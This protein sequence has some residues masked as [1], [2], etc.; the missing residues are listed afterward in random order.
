[1]TLIDVA[2]L[3]CPREFRDGYRRDMQGDFWRDAFDIARTGIA[4]RLES[5]ARDV[6]FA[7]RTLAKARVFT[8]V[9]VLTLALAISVNAT[10]F[11]AISS[12][13]LRPLPFAHSEQLAFLCNGSATNCS[14]MPNSLITKYR[15]AL[16]GAGRI[17][18]WQYTSAALT[19][20]GVPR[21][22]D[23]GWVSAN[24]FDLMNVRPQLGR[25]FDAHDA[26]PGV[27]EV[28]I[29]DRLWRDRFNADPRVIGK[30]LY[31]DGVA[32]NVAGVLPARLAWPDWG[33]APA[34]STFEV[35][36]ALPAGSFAFP[37]AKPF[38]NDL[39]I[40]RIRPG[41]SIAQ[42][43]QKISS[44][45]VLLQHS[46][47][48]LK[49]LSVTA[50]PFA[51]Y[52]HARARRM[53]YLALAAVLAVLL[54]ACANIANLLLA[55]NIARSGELAMRSA[56]GAGSRR[57]VQQLSTEILML[58]LAGG[59]IGLALSAL[60]LAL[61]RGLN[62]S[63][64]LPGA[65]DAHI[66]GAVVA[67]TLVVAVLSAIV[68]GVAPSRV[69][70]GRNLQPHIKRA[71][72]LRTLLAMAEIAL[73]FAV[74]L[75][76]G[77]L[78]RSF[79][80]LA[81]EPLGYQAKNVY[82]ATTELF[83]PRFGSDAARARFI[84]AVQRRV[85]AIPGVAASAVARPVPL[86]NM[87]AEG[88]VYRL[89]GRSYPG[90]N[91]PGAII[92]QITPEYFKALS[93]PLLQGRGFTAA[94]RTGAPYAAIVERQFARSVFPGQSA[95]GK[96][97]LLPNGNAWVP[98]TIVGIAADVN[99]FERFGDMPTMYV[100]AAQWPMEIAQIVVRTNAGVPNLALQVS[101]AVAAA[102][103]L[104]AVQRFRPLQSDV[105]ALLA[106]ARTSAALVGF[107]ACVALLLAL[108]GIYGIVAYSVEQRRHEFGIR[109]AVG[110]RSSHIVRIVL[111][112][113]LRL[114][115]AGLAA[116]IIL[117]VFAARLLTGL[118]TDFSP[119]DPVTFLAV[120][121]LIVASIT[122]ASLV[123]SVRAARLQPSVTLR[124]E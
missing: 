31:L 7:L 34:P 111:F 105:E 14:Q 123:P 36:E 35:F 112:G 65:A 122:L 70:L 56:L 74:V 47:P 16:D 106:P 48:E 11:G 6:V 39:A 12:I 84:D 19:G 66:D 24:F 20:N 38:L 124:Y 109:I 10:V 15:Q 49:N 99:Q 18:A 37:R 17:A 22:V 121:L 78:Y 50:V 102:D 52:Y 53:L 29:S 87:G 42:L 63:R 32:W 64:M 117:S 93:I 103:P 26:Q 28:L 113:A 86:T 82:I 33:D 51:Q 104:E 118:L 77:L 58:S 85:A 89:P 110:A 5:L 23:I 80:R 115:L 21:S 71:K 73:A 81:S 97:I 72:P 119:F 46:Y 79:A 83:G 91:S 98:A 44:T 67:F 60:E 40:V 59:I 30:A 108:A 8:I 61:L 76:S 68:A 4:L 27:R 92:T 41:A 9:A 55:R 62:W 114:T 75:S 1:M 57:I 120:V 94:D 45:T 90:G 3:L 107:L 54:I 101:R 69:M 43:Q 95:L 2:L 13:L 116:G 88:F 96:Q 25:T 100:P